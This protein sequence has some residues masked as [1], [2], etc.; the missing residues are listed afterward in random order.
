LRAPPEAETRIERFAELT[1]AAT[2][3]ALR[4][5]SS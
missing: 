5:N 3:Q 2:A 4:F 1:A